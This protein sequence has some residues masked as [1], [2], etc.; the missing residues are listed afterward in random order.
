MAGAW[1]SPY[2]PPCSGS[3]PATRRLA[4]GS[5]FQHRKGA[6][7]ARVASVTVDD[8][9]TGYTTA[10]ITFDPA[11][12]ATATAVIVGGVITE[13]NVTH[14][15]HDYT[16]PP[17]VII[18]GDN[19]T[20]ASATAVVAGV[21]LY[22]NTQEGITPPSVLTECVGGTLVEGNCYQLDPVNVGDFSLCRKSGWKGLVAVK[23][24][25]GRVGFDQD[26]SDAAAIPHKYQQIQIEVTVSGENW[27]YTQGDPPI[28]QEGTGNGTA[29]VVWTVNQSSG[30]ITESGREFSAAPGN[31]YGTGYNGLAFAGDLSDALAYLSSMRH[32]AGGVTYTTSPANL[33]L[34]PQGTWAEV[35]AGWAAFQGVAHTV[36]SNKTDYELEILVDGAS[37]VT[38][39]PKTPGNLY[40]HESIYIHILLSSKVTAK[41]FCAVPFSLLSNWNLTDDVQYPWRTDPNCT[42]LPMVKFKEYSIARNPDL[43]IVDGLAGYLDDNRPGFGADYTGAI[44]GN[45]LPN[46]CGPHYS[47]ELVEWNPGGGIP[48]TATYWEQGFS[49][50]ATIMEQTA[51]GSVMW[52]ANTGV[53]FV[54]IWAEINDGYSSHNFSRPCG[55]DRYLLEE[56]HFG[57]VTGTSG[58]GS[59]GNEWVVT[60]TFDD[61]NPTIAVGDHVYWSGSVWEVMAGSAYP[62]YKLVS[63]AVCAVPAALVPADPDVF[64]Q[65]RFTSAPAICGRL[66]VTS[67]TLNGGSVDLVL[68]NAA[69]YLRVGDRVDFT[70]Y[71]TAFVE[72]VDDGELKETPDSTGYLV[73]AVADS[74][75]FT[76]TA[77]SVPAAEQTQWDYVKSHGAPH[78]SWNDDLAKADYVFMSWDYDMTAYPSPTYVPTC[79]AGCLPRISCCPSVMAVTPV[80]VATQPWCNGNAHWPANTDMKLMIGYN[81]FWQ[82]IGISHRPDP[83][84]QTPHNVCG[85]GGVPGYTTPMVEARCSAPAGAP[86]MPAGTAARIAAFSPDPA[87]SFDFNYSSWFA[88]PNPGGCHHGDEWV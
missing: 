74:T 37:A 43:L 35:V 3:W 80:P 33:W 86:A 45:P 13:I 48:D 56:D 32:Y 65:L 51:G 19:T 47:F 39:P 83:L 58:D 22:P 7:T 59:I 42:S 68:V 64:A 21:P 23:A 67:A 25:H 28:L 11:Q 38:E 84:F 17:N 26:L 44:T 76:I 18:T 88:P 30:V 70:E 40:W 66:E 2:R 77:A 9:G 46:G 8:G 55:A 61:G 54:Q 12:G 81:W 57:C 79:V 24:F 62:S 14:G 71:D 82:G 27:D 6:D 16:S 4:L 52:E 87:Y 63:P 41:E 31:P 34:I 75:H 1:G 20:P 36:T 29:K 72:T 69:E 50:F 60:S 73:T 85:P 15:G 53:A 49:N 5:C 78:Y 10:T